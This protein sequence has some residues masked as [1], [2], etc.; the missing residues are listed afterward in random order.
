MSQKLNFNHEENQNTYEFRDYP[1][2]EYPIVYGNIILQFFIY[3]RNYGWTQYKDT[4]YNLNKKE[5]AL[6]FIDVLV[7]EGFIK[8]CSNGF[9]VIDENFIGFDCIPYHQL[10]YFLYFT[11]G[12]PVIEKT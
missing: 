4:I 12:K 1:E 7:T 2:L 6:K 8:V 11:K 3:S 10:L 9:S 5:E